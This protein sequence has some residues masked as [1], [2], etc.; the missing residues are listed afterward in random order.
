MIVFVYSALLHRLVNIIASADVYI[1]P[2]IYFII[3]YIG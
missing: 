2:Y 1:T 3:Q